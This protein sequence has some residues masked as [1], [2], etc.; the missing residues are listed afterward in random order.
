MLRYLTLGCSETLTLNV[1]FCLTASP[2]E[3]ASSKVTPISP[4]EALATSVA[5]AVR[6]RRTA[7]NFG[8]VA[9][10]VSWRSLPGIAGWVFNSTP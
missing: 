10:G 1:M 6:N 7:R 8:I 3:G 2:S 9:I 4:P 5:A